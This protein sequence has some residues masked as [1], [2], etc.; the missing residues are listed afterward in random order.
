MVSAW[1][2]TGHVTYRTATTT[3][4]P[5]DQSTWLIAVPQDGDSE[6]LLPEITTKLTQQSRLLPASSIA[7]LSIPSFK[8]WLLFTDQYISH[9]TIGMKSGRHP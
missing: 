5:S 2:E 4:M 7:E 1:T 8:V 6:G 3:V 9:L